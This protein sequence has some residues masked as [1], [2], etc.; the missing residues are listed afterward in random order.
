MPESEKRILLVDDS[1]ADQLLAV[2]AMRKCNPSI[3][4]DCAID[5]IEALQFMRKLAPHDSAPDPDLILLDINMPKMS[6][7]E[8]LETLRKEK[9]ATEIVILTTSTHSRDVERA[10]LLGADAFIAK[11]IEYDDLIAAMRLVAGHLT[12]GSELPPA[13]LLNRAPGC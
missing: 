6:G 5:G 10:Q 8:V 4:V 11:P 13:P 3:H 1:E 12:E 7:L 9:F 2:R